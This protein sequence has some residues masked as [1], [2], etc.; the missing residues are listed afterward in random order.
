MSSQ[1]SEGV[2]AHV[3]SEFPSHEASLDLDLPK[4]T[5][6]LIA[7][8]GLDLELEPREFLRSFFAANGRSITDDEID[9]ILDQYTAVP[10]AARVDGCAEP[11]G[12]GGGDA[13]SVPRLADGRRIT[14]VRK[15]NRNRKL[16]A[17]NMTGGLVEA[18][19]E[20]KVFKD[21]AGLG[22]VVSPE[23]MNLN[24]GESVPPLAFGSAHS[25]FYG[26]A[27]A[28]LE[29][30]TQHALM[31]ASML[32]R[33]TENI[34]KAKELVALQKKVMT[35]EARIKGGSV[36][37]VP[38]TGSFRALMNQNKMLLETYAIAVS[39]WLSGIYLPKITSCLLTANTRP[40]SRLKAQTLLAKLDALSSA[41]SEG[42]DISEALVDEVDSAHAAVY[43]EV[44]RA[45]LTGALTKQMRG[46]FSSHQKREDHQHAKFVTASLREELYYFIATGPMNIGRR[47]TL[48][49]F[50]LPRMLVAVD[51]FLDADVCGT[52][53]VFREGDGHVFPLI[54]PDPLEGV[55]VFSRDQFD[56]G[57]SIQNIT[58]KTTRPER[59][60]AGVEEAEAALR[61]VG[62]T[63]VERHSELVSEARKELATAERSSVSL[64]ITKERSNEDRAMF[65]EIATNRGRESSAES[66]DFVRAG[67]FIYVT[68]KAPAGVPRPLKPTHSRI[69]IHSGLHAP[70][71]PGNVIAA[72]RS[73][74]MDSSVSSSELEARVHAALPRSLPAPDKKRRR[75][76]KFADEEDEVPPADVSKPKSD[77]AAPSPSKEGSPQPLE[78]SECAA[79]SAS[80]DG[81]AASANFAESSDGAAASADAILLL[82][83][84]GASVP[85]PSHVGPGD[86]PEEEPR[87]KRVRK[88]KAAA[89]PVF[90]AALTRRRMTSKLGVRDEGDEDVAVSAVPRRSQ[91]TARDA[92]HLARLDG[93]LIPPVLPDVDED[94]SS[95]DRI[96]KLI[97]D[98]LSTV[99]SVK[100]LHSLFN[101]AVLSNLHAFA[102]DAPLNSVLLGSFIKTFHDTD[103]L[104]VGPTL[105]DEDDI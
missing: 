86:V 66:A 85:E 43:A 54:P 75:S 72:A 11:A 78:P 18:A 73:P 6:D 38:M 95:L 34:N 29:S 48:Q 24:D 87:K 20:T 7:A 55:S 53:D 44:R 60:G 100:P 79:G 47:M 46:P 91:M 57:G 90:A 56:T 8:Q 3:V 52:V 70:S 50:P 88:A 2:P 19:K 40:Q 99:P 71:V 9:A 62:K 81:A 84:A 105:D 102:N 42:D 80:S 14:V 26:S 30:M 49:Q 96:A 23:K 98:L 61:A 32:T 41:L 15:M 74:W 16:E 97:P 13:P 25:V 27:D 76:I 93:D 89:K 101:K 28:A 10:Y 103:P 1:W 82:E 64:N 31:T 68:D 77:A 63:Q 94:E 51:R 39:S 5:L 4:S 12:G 92:R 36:G 67:N 33:L 58:G 22:D 69:S 104:L 45:G 59:T 17:L 65:R 35:I 21:A 83:A 37:D